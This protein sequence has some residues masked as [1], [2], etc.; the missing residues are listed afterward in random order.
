MI[1][2]SEEVEHELLSPTSD[3]WSDAQQPILCT[4]W[5]SAQR[6]NLRT[7][8]VIQGFAEHVS[9]PASADSIGEED[10]NSMAVARR[11]PKH[12]RTESE[13]NGVDLGA[14]LDKQLIASVHAWTRKSIR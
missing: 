8:A 3:G 1:Q 9:L 2:S 6:L 4:P 14:L 13:D 12:P 10:I 7:P 11:S 5:T